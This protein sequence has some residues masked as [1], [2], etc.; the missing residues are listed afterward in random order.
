MTTTTTTAKT[1][2]DSRANVR[3]AALFA[4]ALGG[5]LIFLTGFA[6]ADVLHNAAHDTRHTMSF[7]CH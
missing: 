3:L 7:P 2:I 6:G 4:F 1:G 5:T